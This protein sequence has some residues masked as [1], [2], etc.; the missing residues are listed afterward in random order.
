MF[1]RTTVYILVAAVAAGLG[2]WLSQG[3]GDRTRLPEMDLV[4]LLPEAREVPD[5]TLQR[6]DGATLDKAA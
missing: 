1:N 2:L 6:A 4:T 5:F 3:L